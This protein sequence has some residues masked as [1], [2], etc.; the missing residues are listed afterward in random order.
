M[1]KSIAL[2]LSVILT[3]ALFAG[4]SN[5]TAPAPTVPVQSG[6]SA[7][8]AATTAAAPSTTAQTTAAAADGSLKYITDKGELILG[9]DDTFAPMGFR[10]DKDEIVGYDIDLAKEVTKRLGVKLKLQP[11]D[12]DAK[13][14]ELNTKKIDCIWNGFTILEERRKNIEYSNP[15]LDNNMV[16]VVRED[17]GIKKLS[18]MKGKTLALQGGS[19]AQDALDAHADLKSSVAKVAEFDTNQTCLM[20]LESKGVDAVLID[21]VAFRYYATTNNKKFAVL[22]EKLAAEEYA[23]GFR[24]G[25]KALT[26]AVN[27]A[28]SDMAKDGTLEKITKQWFGENVSKIK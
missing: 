20:D 10:N 25:E 19:S 12:W 28:F 1:K 14:Q 16:L 5:P 22:D 13:E 27:K 21:E 26:E 3:A 24:K 23:V 8:P 4:C 18:D 15:Y 6:S 9:L 7:A 17:S 11:I 2:L